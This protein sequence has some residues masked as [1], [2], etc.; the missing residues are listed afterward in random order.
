MS[1]LT[2]SRLRHLVRCRIS[3]SFSGDRLL[4]AKSQLT[5]ALVVASKR[6]KDRATYSS[7]D[8]RQTAYGKLEVPGFLSQGRE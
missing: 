3:N 7:Q 2:E 6:G 4:T 8:V 5:H 1:L